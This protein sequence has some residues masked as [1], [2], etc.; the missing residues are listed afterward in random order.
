MWQR[1]DKFCYAL[2][3]AHKFGVKIWCITL[4]VSEN[5]VEYNKEIP[6]YLDQNK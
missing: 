4:S 1:D 5:G 2:Y 3:E 6:I